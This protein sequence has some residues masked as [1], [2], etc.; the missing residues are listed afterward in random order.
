MPY[1]ATLIAAREVFRLKK[2][3]LDSLQKTLGSPVI[4]ELAQGEAY[5]FG[6]EALP[7]S[8][9]LAQS[10]L[11]TL[12]LDLILQATQGRMKRLVVADMDSTIIEQECLDEVADARGLKAQIAPITEA[13]MQGQM[14][15]GESLRMRL[16]VLKDTPVALL[17][18]VR[19]ERIAFSK[20][21]RTLAATL[22]SRGVK[23]ALV[24]GGLEMFVEKVAQDLAFDHW[25]SNRVEI[26]DD[27]LTGR[28]LE[29]LIGAEAKR[30]YLQLLSKK[31]GL[32]SDETAVIGDGANDISMMQAAGISFAYR[33]K[34][35]VARAASAH[36][37]HASLEA[38]LFAF[39]IPRG[40][41][42]EQTA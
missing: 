11:T 16:Q 12:P 19:A 7:T 10:G 33:G 20:G 39:G 28:V 21:A 18:T 30:D 37:R 23:L 38:V 9:S 29:P 15:F 8:D 14:D 26:R 4:T 40:E 24:S 5:D 27:K 41:F 35:S 31:L 32:S 25:L 42:I 2:T 3:H 1:V 34:P 17:N 6:L 36:L 22:K 13:A